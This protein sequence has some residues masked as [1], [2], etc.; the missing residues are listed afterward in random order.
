MEKHRYVICLD[1]RDAGVWTAAVLV[2]TTLHAQWGV[3]QGQRSG[4]ERYW[5]NNYEQCDTLVYFIPFHFILM[6]IKIWQ[7]CKDLWR[8]V[9]YTCTVDI[10]EFIQVTW[11]KQHSDLYCSNYI[12][13]IFCMNFVGKYP[14]LNSAETFI[15]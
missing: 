5:G 2:D 3:D 14:D 15:F 7:W 10:K 6:T 9:Q 4:I 13:E 1:I 11:S 8:I 12:Q